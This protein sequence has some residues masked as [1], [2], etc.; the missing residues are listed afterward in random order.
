M[1]PPRTAA[2]LVI[3][4]ELLT[5]KI[6]DT[7][8]GHLARELFALGIA[9]E[10]AIFCRDEIDVIVAD[11]NDLRRAHDWV[12]TS[13]GVGPT[14]DDVT[15]KALAR[16]FDRPIA[17][18]PAIETLLR[19]FIGDRISDGHLRMA[20]VP[21]GAELVTGSGGHW[22]VLL[23]D[24]VFVLPGLPEAFE[25]QL[26]ILRERLAGDAP[27]IS[28]A[29]HTT[30]DEGSIA[31]LLE[32]LAAGHPEVAIGSYPKWNGPYRVAVTFDG[33][34]SVKVDAAVQALHRILPPET[35][36]PAT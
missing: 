13:G 23:I 6:R 1:K 17:R 22:P 19:R 8:F 36:V 5:G 26:P 29:V 11:L 10:R 14:H 33:R 15:I 7:N 2:A 12:F 28:R 20:D 4:N 25:R 30:R 16:A 27:F 24:N 18:S 21:V 31:A 34:D 35:I 32:E 9:L 3:G